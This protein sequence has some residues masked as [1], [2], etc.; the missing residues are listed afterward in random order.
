V[1][2][3]EEKLRHDLFEKR[4][5]VFD[6]AR[7]L[8]CEVTV[9]RSASD[10]DLRAFTIGIGD[11]VFLVNGACAATSKKCDSGDSSLPKGFAAR[12]KHGGCHEIRGG[13]SDFSLS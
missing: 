6:A 11:A 10:E 5:R 9:H 1:D 7:K 2:I 8:L 12:K 13:G 3:A 4:Y